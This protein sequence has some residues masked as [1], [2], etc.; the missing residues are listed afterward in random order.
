[1]GKIGKKFVFLLLYFINTNISFGQCDGGFVTVHTDFDI[2]AGNPD[3]LCV[4]DCQKYW[5]SNAFCPV[6][7]NTSFHWLFKNKTYND[8]LIGDTVY[9]CYNDTGYFFY[10]I[11]ASNFNLD[12]AYFTDA[13]NIILPCPPQAKFTSSTQ[14]ICTDECI[15][16]TDQSSRLPNNWQWYFEGGTP[17]TFDGQK[18][19]SICYA[20]TG[21]FDVQLIVK[22]NYGADT[23]LLSD[24]VEVLPGPN[25]IPVEQT[26]VIK[27]GDVITMSACARGNNYLWQPNVA[28]IF[29][30]DSLLTVQPDETQLYSS[31]ITTNNGCAKNCTYEVKV[32]NGLL[33]P[34]AF[35]PNGDGINDLFRILNTN[36][37]LLS[38]SIY[39]RWGELVFQT[40]NISQG[41][42]GNFLDTKQDMGVYIWSADY[43]ITKTGKRKLAKGNVTLLR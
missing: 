8:T 12:S 26:F 28:V 24:Y 3:T 27:E 42:D 37:T 20:D 32:Q 13:L 5:V 22:S 9:Y 1:M 10:D 41:W 38:F 21:K 11:Y 34:T 25:V 17:S 35:S 7:N 43:L 19:P 40:K 31:I 6:F 15:E 23:L 30:E 18:P 16:F 4:G 36:I 29:N 33:L 14:K 39:N 2:Y